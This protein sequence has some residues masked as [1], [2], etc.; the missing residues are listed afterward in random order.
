ML[1]VIF[2]KPHN[3]L[4]FRLVTRVADELDQARDLYQYIIK[5]FEN[6]IT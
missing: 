6:C 2:N 4:H 5:T 1:F 3:L